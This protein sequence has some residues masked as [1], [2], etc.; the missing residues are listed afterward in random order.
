MWLI[1]TRDL[2]SK[3]KQRQVVGHQ[4]FGTKTPFF[5]AKNATEHASLYLRSFELHC[6]L[7]SAYA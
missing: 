3:R 1:Y 5:V 4:D 6:F 7:G 2:P